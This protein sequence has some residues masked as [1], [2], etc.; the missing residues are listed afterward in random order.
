MDEGTPAADVSVK[1]ADHES[2]IRTFLVNNAA[3]LATD[4]AQPAHHS[5]TV[6]DMDTSAP[7]LAPHSPTLSPHADLDE[8]QRRGIK[9]THW[10]LSHLVKQ[11]QQQQEQQQRQEQRQVLSEPSPSKVSATA[12]WLKMLPPRSILRKSSAIK[13]DAEG[14]NLIAVCSPDSRSRAVVPL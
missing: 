4:S 2:A 7:A 14:G 3:L 1:K 10:E 8:P 5:P 6:T 12:A 13:T 9:R 11:Q